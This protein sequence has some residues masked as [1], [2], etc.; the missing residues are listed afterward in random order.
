M[1]MPSRPVETDEI[2]EPNGGNDA[3]VLLPDD[4]E[5]RIRMLDLERNSFWTSYF[6]VG[7]RISEVFGDF[8][9]HELWKVQNRLQQIYRAIDELDTADARLAK[10]LELIREGNGLVQELMQEINRYAEPAL[11]R[12]EI[13]PE[14]IEPPV[15]SPETDVRAVPLLPVEPGE[16]PAR[17]AP[18]PILRRRD[19]NRRQVLKN[20]G[21]GAAAAGGIVVTGVG[22]GIGAAKVEESLRTER[23]DV[24]LDKAAHLSDR[25]FVRD[26]LKQRNV[27]RFL[28]ASDEYLKT[29]EGMRELV[30]HGKSTP[31]SI[32]YLRRRLAAVL[33]EK[34][35]PQLKR[36]HWHAQVP[37][38]PI[39]LYPAD[40][41]GE[42]D[43]N[44][45]DFAAPP[46]TIIRSIRRGIVVSTS[47]SFADVFTPDTNE[48]MR[49]S[50]LGEVRVEAGQ[51]IDV[52]HQ[53]GIVG[54]TVRNTPAARHE[55]HLRLEI[56]RLNFDG[57]MFAESGVDIRD[58]LSRVKER[59]HRGGL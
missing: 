39:E 7:G 28:T 37:F 22:L 46:G 45:A 9:P 11:A 58:Q 44:A 41:A 40:G 48:F 23:P 21:L 53:I 29:E 42:R 30:L 35:R 25:D 17:N 57:R 15:L 43:P 16:W 33:A 18:A 14:P 10:E 1:G 19:Q 49:Y 4:L 3:E 8:P 34:M 52:G 55:A 6:R 12:E 31:V 54:S 36:L 26:L 20:I 38:T 24:F 32:P 50:Q 13:E 56:N 47:R 59:D 2:Q 5:Q 27:M 51:V